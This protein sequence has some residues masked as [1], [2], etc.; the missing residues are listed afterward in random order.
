MPLRSRRTPARRRAEAVGRRQH[1]T[2]R[3][4]LR[5]KADDRRDQDHD[6]HD[7][8]DN[9]V[10]RCGMEDVLIPAETQV[11]DTVRDGHT[12]ILYPVV[13]VVTLPNGLRRLVLGEPYAE[14]TTVSGGKPPLT[15]LR[16]ALSTTAEI[17]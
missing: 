4:Q 12:G 7:Q 2:R 5:F 10:Y 6:E 9:R 14:Q 8:A 15:V 11:P 3:R 13:D 16:G 1:L 17:S